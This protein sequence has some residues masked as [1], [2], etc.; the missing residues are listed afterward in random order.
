MSQKLGSVQ[1]RHGCPA[2]IGQL[3]AP[4]HTPAA[5]KRGYFVTLAPQ[6]ARNPDA[7]AFVAWLQE[8]AAAMEAGAKPL[9]AVR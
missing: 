8:E 9:R 6:A 7:Q 1:P 3:V 2:P 5:S 4:F